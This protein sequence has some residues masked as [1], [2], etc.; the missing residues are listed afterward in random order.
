MSQAGGNSS[1]GGGGGGGTVTSITAGTGLIAVPNPIIGVGTI[2]LSIPVSIADGGTNA[3]TMT[4]TN[5]VNYFD[6]TSIVTTTV[7]T[8]GDVLTSNGVGLAPTFQPV[9]VPGVVVS[10]TGND[11]VVVGPDGTGTINVIGSP[12]SGAFFTGN[13]GTF[14]ESLSFNFLN[15]PNTDALGNGIISMNSVPY[16]SNYG[17]GNIFV[18]ANSG[19]TTL[20]VINA[21]LNTAIGTSTLAS[22]TDGAANSA[23]GYLSLNLLTTGTGNTAVGFEALPQI[24]TASSNTGVGENCMNSLLAGASYNTCLGAA[25]LSGMTSGAHNIAIG[26]GTGQAYNGAQSSNILIGPSSIGLVGDSN[27]IR[28]GET[29]A[30]DGQQNACFIAGISGINVGSVANLVSIDTGTDQLG[31]TA[32]TAGTGITVTPGANTITIAT[33]GTTVLTYVGVNH[34]ASPYTVLGTDEYISADVT[35]GVISILLPN[36]PATGRVFI[37]KDKVGLA[38]TSNI[39]VTTVGGA[40]T[41]DGA[42]TFVMNTAYESIQL[43]FNGTSYEVY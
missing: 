39:T 24:T 14:T 12:A 3:I 7:G 40:V 1:S 41:I 42:T 15:I 17:S 34:A 23:L 8:A 18:G 33:T 10:L 37:V 36:A 16:F 2:S 27:I 19:N 35:A 38:A 26:F 30:G 21:Q 20:T 28:I 32:I 25:T 4:N 29:G 13:T 5:G 11:S 43:I 6:G 31:T 9:T 22:L